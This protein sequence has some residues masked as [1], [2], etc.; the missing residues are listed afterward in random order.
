MKYYKIIVDNSFAGAINSG[1]FVTERGTNKRLFYS[2]EVS[3]QYVSYNG[4]LYHDYW[5]Q[6]IDDNREYIQARIIEITEQE[7]NA[8]IDA[9]ENNTPIEDETEEPEN[10]YPIIS[11]PEQMEDIEYVRTA[12]IKAMSNAC[13]R[14][15]ESGFDL[16][17]NGAEKHFSLTTQDQLNLMSLS[18]LDSDLIPYHADGEEVVFY[19]PEEIQRI[20]NA[21]NTL[22][23]Y[24][25]TYFN[26]LKTYINALT[27]IEDIDAIEYGVDIPDEYQSDVFKALRGA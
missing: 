19:S 15:I 13:H 1:L 14:A 17:I 7:Y 18:T 9:I 26:T 10:L 6:P 25:T 21:A 22:R 24:Q 2:N 5:M 11:T 20:I 3:G 16:Y 4:V 12:K 23:I 27:T 8:Y